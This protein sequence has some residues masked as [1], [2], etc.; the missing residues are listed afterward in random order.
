MHIGG[1]MFLGWYSRRHPKLAYDAMCEELDDLKT[2]CP[3]ELNSQEFRMFC[4]MISTVADDMN[5][6]SDTLKILREICGRGVDVST[7]SILTGYSPGD[8][9]YDSAMRVDAFFDSLHKRFSSET[10]CNPIERKLAGCVLDAAYKCLSPRLDSAVTIQDKH[11]IKA[12]LSVHPLTGM[13]AIMMRDPSALVGF[14]P[15]DAPAMCKTSGGR[16]AFPNPGDCIDAF[17]A[18][19]IWTK[20][21]EEECPC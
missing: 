19:D 18:F 12:P 8:A 14:L 17:T 5:T 9:A 7:R 4:A 1:G 15:N 20:T 16:F 10:V 2:R 3:K 13:L 6:T 11:L 21:L